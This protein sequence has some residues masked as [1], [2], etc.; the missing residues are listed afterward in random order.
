MFSFSVVELSARLVGSACTTINYSG[1]LT[2]FAA[3]AL[4]QADICVVA[5]YAS[6]AR[7]EIIAKLLP[8][9]AV[10]VALGSQVCVACG[11]TRR[12]VSHRTLWE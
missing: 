10:G 4:M 3:V 8:A 6:N 1:L 12:A 7:W 2:L 9:T 11:G 5:N